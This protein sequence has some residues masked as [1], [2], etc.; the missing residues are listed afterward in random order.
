M[1]EGEIA[2]IF[3]TLEEIK[4]ALKVIYGE[5]EEQDGL[6]NSLGRSIT[7]NLGSELT[8][9]NASLD[10]LTRIMTSIE[11][12]QYKLTNL[13]KFDEKISKVAAMVSKIDLNN[14]EENI[15]RIQ[16]TL[17]TYDG[18]LTSIYRKL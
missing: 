8:K 9:I 7:R 16:S 2:R 17:V 14:L 11:D 5:N 3:A 4:Q 18:K 10:K 12:I 15:A 13:A 6:I 1:T